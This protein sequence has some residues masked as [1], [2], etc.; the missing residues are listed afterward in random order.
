MSGIT[1]GTTKELNLILKADAQ[2]SV[3]AASG[4]LLRLDSPAAKITILHASTGR[5]N[6]GDILLANAS[7]AIIL[8]FNIGIEPGVEGTATRE[9]VE[10]RSYNIIYKLI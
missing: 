4:A 1:G 5:V 8:A 10:I 2:G 9:S 7:N 6:E 3:E